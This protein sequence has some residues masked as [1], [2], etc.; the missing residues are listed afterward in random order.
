VGTEY[1][2]AKYERIFQTSTPVFLEDMLDAQ[3]DKELQETLLHQN[4]RAL[5]ILPLW[6]GKRQIGVLLLQSETKHVFSGR[7]TRTYPP[8]VDQMAIAVE[9]QRLFEQTQVSLSETELLYNVSNRIAQ[10]SED[11]YAGTGG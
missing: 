10:A 4:I 5:A 3:I 6:S 1:L 7:E 9:N 8:L 2:R 11:R